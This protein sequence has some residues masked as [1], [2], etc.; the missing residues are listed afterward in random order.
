M[1]TGTFLSTLV[2]YYKKAATIHVAANSIQEAKSLSTITKQTTVEPFCII[3]RDAVNLPYI[4]D[5]NTSLLNMFIAYYLQ[6][7]SVLVNLKD[8]RVKKVLKSLGTDVTFTLESSVPSMESIKYKL[9]SYG[10]E[11]DDVTVARA[12]SSKNNQEL[13]SATNM[14]IGKLIDVDFSMPG[15]DP[16]KRTTLTVPVV[17]RMLVNIVNTKTISTLLVRHKEDTSFTERWYSWRS[18]R[19]S[20]WR[21]LVLAQDLIR[22]SIKNNIDPDSNIISSVDGRVT[23]SFINKVASAS[24]KLDNNKQLDS[25]DMYSFGVASNLY[26]ITSKEA[27]MF[28]EQLRGKLSSAKVREKLFQNGYAMVLAV[29]DID[30]ER[31]KFYVQGADGYNDL[32]V[33]EIKASSKGKGTELVD[34]MKMLQMGTVSTF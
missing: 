17:V 13:A 7:V 24:I 30:R 32:S 19:I 11:E 14:S 8:V 23:S 31:V 26:V 21:D 28:E 5:V 3:S 27:A 1:S 22:E 10:L 4:S 2:D 6:G 34:M 15:L 25:T 12:G 16:D 20:F 29:I 33:K 18:G 9:P